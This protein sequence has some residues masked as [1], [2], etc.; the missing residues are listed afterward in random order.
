MKLKIAK[1]IVQEARYVEA[2]RVIAEAEA[3]EAQKAIIEAEAIDEPVDELEI[4]D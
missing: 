2:Q 1:V 3:I 4:G